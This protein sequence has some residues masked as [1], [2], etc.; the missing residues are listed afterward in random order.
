MLACFDPMQSDAKR[1][2]ERESRMLLS[3]GNQSI[4]QQV[5]SQTRL[6]SPLF[7]YC[8]LSREQIRAMHIARQAKVTERGSSARLLGRPSINDRSE[9]NSLRESHQGR[10]GVLGAN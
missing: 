6:V 1:Q 7:G 5:R 4:P 2:K 10:T 3:D 8:G 9:W